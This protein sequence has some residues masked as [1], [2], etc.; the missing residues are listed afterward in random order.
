MSG[1]GSRWKVQAAVNGYV[2]QGNYVT[3]YATFQQGTVV[4]PKNFKFLPAQLQQAITSTG[5]SATQA[6]VVPKD[7]TIPLVP[8]VEVLAVQ[9]PPVDSSTGRTAQGASS[10]IL[11][12]T[13]E[14]AQELVFATGSSTLYLGLLP[15]DNT[16]GYSQPGTIGV[17]LGKVIGVNKG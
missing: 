8:A 1:S 11:N 4:V 2:Q 14:D 10:Y 13:P 17:P 7:F 5:T 9:N 12:M 3:I 16:D 15:P 6:F